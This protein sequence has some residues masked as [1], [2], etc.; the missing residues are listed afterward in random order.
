MLLFCIDVN[1]CRL[2]TLSMRLN[3]V[4]TVKVRIELKES[5]SKGCG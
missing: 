3:G 4:H 5:Y 1:I 2:M